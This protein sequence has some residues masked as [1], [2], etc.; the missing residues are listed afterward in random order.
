MAERRPIIHAR[1]H[2][3]GSADPIP[4][5]ERIHMVGLLAA[6][7]AAGPGNRGAYYFAS[8]DPSG[9]GGGGGGIMFETEPQAG[10]WLDLET[11]AQDAKGYGVTFT[12]S[13]GG[14]IAFL[15]VHGGTN[16][17]AAGFYFSQAPGADDGLNT[18]F[19]E[20][21]NVN[22]Q[23]TALE[24][25][26]TSTGSGVTQAIV[27]GA[28][29]GG[30]GRANA[31]TG[32][33]TAGTGNATGVAG[34]ALNAAANAGTLKGVD[35]FVNTGGHTNTAS[36]SFVARSDTG[37]GTNDDMR[38]LAGGRIQMLRLPTSPTGLPAG[39]LWNN[40]GV[41]SIV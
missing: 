25:D 3:P 23:A 19:V 37:T 5:L 32:N 14:G 8:D 27:A 34:A 38:I 39:S 33:A 20:G 17:A 40:A 35:A 18:V 12:D 36:Y 10:G 31:V 30:A 41:V 1:D 24:A 2:A 21:K 9:G 15:T 6:R 22:V 28:K 4:W 7:P 13:G 11:T 29:S 26:Q 16:L